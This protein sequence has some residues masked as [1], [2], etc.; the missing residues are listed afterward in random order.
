MEYE[1]LVLSDAQMTELVFSKAKGDTAHRESI[2]DSWLE[3]TKKNYCDDLHIKEFITILNKWLSNHHLPIVI[4]WFTPFLDDD[5]VEWEVK[6]FN[7][8]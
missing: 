7:R 8:K 6:I 5:T 1:D 3:F 4:E 2:K